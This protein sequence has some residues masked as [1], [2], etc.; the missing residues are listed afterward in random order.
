MLAPALLGL[1]TAS[2]IGR[3][4]SG[5]DRVKLSA[6]G[7]ALLITVL[8]LPKVRRLLQPNGSSFGKLRIRAFNRHHCMLNF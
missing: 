1:D 6:P 8:R 2:S 3:N 4:E 5:D 7:C